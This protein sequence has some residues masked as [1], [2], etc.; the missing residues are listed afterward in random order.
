MGRV[1]CVGVLGVG[2]ERLLIGGLAFQSQRLD[3]F[4]QNN[5]L[6][7]TA[8]NQQEKKEKEQANAQEYT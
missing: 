4:N 2:R 5:R 3:Q 6:T 8:T 7:T 1:C